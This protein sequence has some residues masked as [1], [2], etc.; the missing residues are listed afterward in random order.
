M[1]GAYSRAAT[2]EY[3][4]LFP[5]LT[6]F[7]ACKI[8]AYDPPGET[9]VCIVSDGAVFD[10]SS[11]EFF[12]FDV[13][14]TLTAWG[15]ATEIL[16][17]ACG[18]VDKAFTLRDEAGVD[19]SVGYAVRNSDGE[20]VTPEPLED[21]VGSSVTMRYKAVRSFGEADGFAISEGGTLLAAVEQGTWGPALEEE[22]V[23]GLSVTSGEPVYELEDDCGTQS[24]SKIVFT[25]DEQYA[26]IPYSQTEITVD[27]ASYDIFA[28]DNGTYIELNCT[29]MGGRW[30]WAAFRAAEGGLPD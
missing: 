16:G 30:E 9:A 25:G 10:T 8:A 4:M 18:Q 19:W 26:E 12:T 5:L 24:Y 17:D 14:G 29:D 6:L 3:T 28:V 2:K 22:D 15:S 20:T 11:D 21:L 13:S 27:G 23:P 7:A 1:E